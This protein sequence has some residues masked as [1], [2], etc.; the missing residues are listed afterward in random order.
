MPADDTTVDAPRPGLV[1][2]VSERAWTRLGIVWFALVLAYT[3]TRRSAY[4]SLALFALEAAVPAT[5]FA[6][7][8]TRET[9]RVRASGFTGSLLPLV[10]A[11]LPL[12]LTRLPDAPWAR[13]HPALFTTLLLLPTASMVIGYLYL[14]RSFAI[15]A[16]ARALKTSG[17]YRL[18][19]HPVY[20]SQI[21]CAGVVAAFKL[22]PASVA[23]LAGFVAIQIARARCE[24]RVLEEAHGQ[25]WR[26][27]A[28]RV[29]S[30]WP[31]SLTWTRSAPV[32]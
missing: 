17:P 15:M 19:R 10:G 7:Y 1:A 8:L 11:V 22:S 31:R 21:A 32:E 27:Y 26:D 3:L 12:A 2:R 16:E 6:A 25:E 28:A 13:G 23:L 18:A 5:I 9:A 30:F 24:D 14:N 4:W 29:G 20:A